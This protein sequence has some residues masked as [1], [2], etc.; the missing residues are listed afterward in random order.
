MKLLFGTGNKFKYNLMKE[1]LKEL[2]EIEVITP[3]DL[4]INIEINEDG[5]T[6]AENAMKKAKTYYEL[7]KLPTIAED[8]G[9][10]IDEFSEEDQPGLFVK[11]ING[12][13]DLSDEEI[14]NYY[15]QKLN[16]YGG[17]SLASYHTGVCLID[18][19]GNIFSDTIEETKFLLTSKKFETKVDKGGILELISYDINANKYF[20][21]RTKEEEKKHYEKL[22]NEYK[23]IVKKYILKK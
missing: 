6:P 15:I 2:K 7:T 18:E 10:Y 8:S 22:D 23:K 13:D 3:I 11:R 12:R 19:N 1:R 5:K 9:L 20:G 21:Q 14:L 4:N 16:L 17:K